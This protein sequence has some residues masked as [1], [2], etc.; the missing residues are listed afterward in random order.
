VPLKSVLFHLP[1][2]GVVVVL[3]GGVFT[4]NGEERKG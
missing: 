3:G 2:E 4:E 1:N